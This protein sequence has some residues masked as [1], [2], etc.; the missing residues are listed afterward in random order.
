[1]GG[2]CHRQNVGN[3]H[4]SFAELFLLF[5]EGMK[6]KTESYPVVEERKKVMY[7]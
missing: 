7:M 1:V 3:S 2:G 5:S 6:R 4:L